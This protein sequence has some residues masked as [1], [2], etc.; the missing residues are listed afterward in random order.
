MKNLLKLLIVVVAFL[1]PAAYSQLPSAYSATFPDAPSDAW[2][3]PYV[4][5]LVEDGIM[6]GYPDG[7]FGSWDPINRAEFAKVIVELRRQLEKPW[8][9]EHLFEIILVVITLGGWASIA[10][11]VSRLTSKP[12]GETPRVPREPI[13]RE[14]RLIADDLPEPEP[15][16]RPEP[17]SSPEDASK[18]NEKTNWWV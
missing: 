11:M 15:F 6:E 10:L 1:L 14:S 5:E 12:F 7:R 2:F 4:E 8:W 17:T 3:T 13:Q 9:E 18:K 16:V